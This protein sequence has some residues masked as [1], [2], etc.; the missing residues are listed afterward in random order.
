MLDSGGGGEL[1]G[2]RE[3]VLW[4]GVFDIGLVELSPSADGFVK[5]PGEFGNPAVLV[6]PETLLGDVSVCYLNATRVFAYKPEGRADADGWLPCR[7]RRSIG[8]AVTL[9]NLD[10]F[11]RRLSPLGLFFL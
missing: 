3:D 5:Q 8:R 7:R 2:G 1:G 6:H 4:H 11:R 9:A 10:R